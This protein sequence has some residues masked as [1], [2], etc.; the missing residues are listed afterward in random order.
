MI[1]RIRPGAV[2]LERDIGPV[3]VPQASSDLA[4]PGWSIYIVVGRANE[5][6][7]V[8]DVGNVDA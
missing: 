3:K 5:T 8:V 6:W 4:Q 2:W 7:H 1:D